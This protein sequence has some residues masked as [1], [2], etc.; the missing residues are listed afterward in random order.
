MLNRVTKNTNKYRIS[1]LMIE[2]KKLLKKKPFL[3]GR[4]YP[5]KLNQNNRKIKNCKK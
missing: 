3:M 1:I 5:E 4:L 2:S